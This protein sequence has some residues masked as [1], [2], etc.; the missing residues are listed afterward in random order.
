MALSSDQ[1]T[2]LKRFQKILNQLDKISSVSNN[3]D[4]KKRVSKEI[5]KYK[6]KVLVISPSGI[7]DTIQSISKSDPRSDDSNNS[8][9]KKDNQHS[10][11]DNLVVMRLCPH[12]T[13]PEINLLSTLINLFEI[14]YIPVLSDAHIKFDFSTLN[15]RNSVVKLFENIKRTIKVLIETIEEYA[16]TDKQEF[17]EQ[18][19]RMKNKQSRVFISEASEF[20]KSMKTFVDKTL[21]D[22]SAGENIIN[23]LEEV[24][25]FN[26]KTESATLLQGKK[27]KFAL[28]EISTFLE[29]ALANISIP[30]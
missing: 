8:K 18:M 6:A 4:Q 17:K 11:F 12:S 14:E 10:I 22:L 9:N 1:I 3:E 25:R 27:I 16:S 29:T 5:Q 24:I 23:N 30:K 19:G 7:P 20:F 26:P 2:E 15:E 13:D 28:E 21:Q